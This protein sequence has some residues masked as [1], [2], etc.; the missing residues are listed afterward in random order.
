VPDGEPTLDS[1]LGKSIDLLR[2][3]GTKIAVISNASLL[4]Q[5]SVQD[6]L[7]KAD[8]VSLKIDAVSQDIWRRINR[9]HRDLDLSRILEA[10]RQF[11]AD[12][13]GK[14]VSETMLLHGI[15]D[16]QDTI[17]EIAAFMGKLKPAKSYLSI[18][19][20]PPAEAAVYPAD[21][22]ILNMAYHLFSD[23]VQEVELLSGYEGKAFSF[24]GNVE[25]DL[26]NIV[27]VHP[28][29]SEAVRDFLAKAGADWAIIDKLVDQNLLFTTEYEGKIFY[30]RRLKT[31]N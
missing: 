6:D 7:G 14:L 5:K 9:P 2:P 1:N 22:N 24:T 30:L 15:N 8:W 3:L 25:E 26:L 16:S 12:Y 28:M 29:R 31:T 17:R 4:R 27:A 23:K 21:E 18:P 11:S 10:M 13:T 19:T 20:R